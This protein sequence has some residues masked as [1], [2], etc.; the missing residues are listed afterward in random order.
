M[1]GDFLLSRGIDKKKQIIL[2]LKKALKSA[3]QNYLFLSRSNSALS[4]LGQVQG[5]SVNLI[6]QE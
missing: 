6:Y 5:E 2:K 3:F 4:H 1:R